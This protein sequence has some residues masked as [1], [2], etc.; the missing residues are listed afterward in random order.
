MNDTSAHDTFGA[1][2]FERGRVW[3][4]Y[5]IIVLAFM[6][7]FIQIGIHKGRALEREEISAKSKRST[8]GANDKR[9]AHEEATGQMDKRAALIEI[10]RLAKEHGVE[11][12]VFLTRP[13]MDEFLEDTRRGAYVRY[14]LKHY[15][16]PV[17]KIELF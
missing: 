7:V 16:V 15:G 2:L 4:V 13:D 14:G 9:S 17:E 11:V 5:V 8:Q 12:I 1:W 10:H 3:L 6:V